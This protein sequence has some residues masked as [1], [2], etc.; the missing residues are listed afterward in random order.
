M[1]RPVVMWGHSYGGIMA[2]EVIRRLRD[3]HHCEPV[4]FVVTGTATPRGIEKWKNREVLLKGMVADNSLEYLMSISRF[5]EDPE[6][7]KAIR[8]PMRRD[9]PLLTSYRFEPMLPL[10]C[11]ITAFAARQDDMVYTDEIREWAHHT[12]GG[13]EL[14]EVDGDHWFLNRNRDLLS[15]T[16]RNIAAT[17]QPINADHIVHSSAAD[18]GAWSEPR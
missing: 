5:V 13:F 3:R 7:F 15:A 1:D 12:K 14:I 17:C 2:W 8:D 9:F 10:N 6:F 4:H 16:F 18:K 11:P